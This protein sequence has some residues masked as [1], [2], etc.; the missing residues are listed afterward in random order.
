M[1]LEEFLRTLPKQT[2][3]FSDSSILRVNE[4]FL[5]IQG[6]GTR[7]GV[8]CL[9]VRLHGCKLRCSW[10]DTTYAIDRRDGGNYIKIEDVVAKIED[11]GCKFVEFTGGEP[12]EQPNIY[13][14][15]GRLCDDGYTVAVETG[16][17]IFAP[18]IDT[19]VIRIFD[20]KCPGSKMDTLNDYRNL[21]DLR[22]ND[23]VKFVIASEEDYLF[24]KDVV[25]QYDLTCKCAAVLFSP[26]F[27]SIEPRDIVE[28]IL[29][30]RL[31]V[32]FQLQMHKFIWHPEQ[33]GV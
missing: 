9:F 23:E 27:G 32:R 6:E 10:C 22:P 3:E 31:D 18:H 4:I 29:R 24:A 7:A 8:P 12:L 17:H 15:L 5:S 20:I 19:R 28:W 21:D 26:V 1:T 25:K 30:D 13:P 14:L 16:G 33:R 11:Y 2:P